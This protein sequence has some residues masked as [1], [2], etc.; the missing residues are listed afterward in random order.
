MSPAAVGKATIRAIVK[1]KTE[2]AVIPGPGKTLRAI[3]D[4]FPAIGPTMNKAAGAEESMRKVVQYREHQ[5]RLAG[6]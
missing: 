5:S 1:D 3:L 2:L 6:T 4:R